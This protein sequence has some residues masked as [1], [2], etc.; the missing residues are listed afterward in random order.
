MSKIDVFNKFGVS[1]TQGNRIGIIRFNVSMTRE[2]ALV[3]AAYIVA[4]AD[5]DNEF[6]KYLGALYDEA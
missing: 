3:L 4:L 5:K 6:D 2:E 1:M